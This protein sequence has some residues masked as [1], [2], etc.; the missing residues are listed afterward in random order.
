MCIVPAHY[1]G[2]LLC[3]LCWFTVWACSG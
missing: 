2:P 1:M 3:V